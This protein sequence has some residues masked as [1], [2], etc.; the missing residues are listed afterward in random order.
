MMTS[1]YQTLTPSFRDG[2]KDRTRNLEVPGSMPRIAPE[3]QRLAS[4]RKARRTLLDIGTHGL[5]LVGAA[6]QFLLLDGFGEQRRA[7]IDRQLVQ[8]PLGSA[9]RIRAFARDRARLR[10]RLSPRIVANLRRK[11]VGQR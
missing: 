2:P 4:I 6:E 10:E 3:R 1:D 5:E 7:G 11:A 9:D 8:H